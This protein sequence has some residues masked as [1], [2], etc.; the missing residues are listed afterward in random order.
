MPHIAAV[1]WAIRLLRLFITNL[2]ARRST[3]CGPFTGLRIPWSLPTV[4]GL[5][6][7][8]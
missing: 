5:W 2:R 4:M 3:R 1:I 8:L 7:C 6:V